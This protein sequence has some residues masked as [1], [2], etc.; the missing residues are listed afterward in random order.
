MKINNIHPDMMGVCINLVVF[1]WVNSAA[2]LYMTGNMVPKSVY[3]SG[4]TPRRLVTGFEKQYGQ[5][6]RRIEAPA[7]MTVESVFYVKSLQGGGKATDDWNTIYVVFKN[8]EIGKYDLLELPRYNTQNSYIGFEYVYDK[9]MLRR[10]EEKDATFRKGEVFA[11]SPRISESGDW[12][13]GMEVK[14]AAM[15]HFSTEE[16]GIC[17]TDEFAHKRLRCMFKHEREF[18]YNEDEFVP[19]F[20]YGDDDNPRPFPEEGEGLRQDRIVMGFRRRIPEM[21]LT[22]LT[23]KALRTPDRLY[24]ILFRAPKNCKVM[25]IQVL[26]ERM[27]NRS[28]NRNNQTFVDQEHN[29]TLIA[30][31]KEDNKFRNDIL[32]WYHRKLYANGNQD[33]DITVELG[34][35]ITQAYSNQTVNIYGNTERDIITKPRNFKRAALKD[36]NIKIVLKEEVVGKQKY[37]MS[38]MNGDKGVIV[39]IIKAADAPTYPDGTRAEVIVNNTPAFRRQIYAMLMEL[40]INFISDKIHKEVVMLRNS[41]NYKAAY[42]RLYLFYRTGFPDFADIVDRA[43]PDDEAKAEHVDYVAKHFI[44]V[45]VRSDASLYGVQIIRELSKV[46]KYKP[47][48]V[49]FTDV[50]GMQVESINPVLISNLYYMLLD[51]F[52]TDMSSQ[53]LPKAN[54]FGFPAKLNDKD[55]YAGWHKDQ[56]NKN[57]G[58]TEGRV[59]KNQKGADETLKRFTMAYSPEA[60]V[61][62][63]K[64]YIRAEDPFEVDIIVKPEEY[65]TNRA[66]QMGASMLSDS[67][68]AIRHELPSDKEGQI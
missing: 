22:M 11:L 30:Y 18:A 59:E 34:T 47:E 40:S 19:L 61:N 4:R 27:K 44:S 57:K 36:W 23:K 32:H 9:E 65:V 20:L 38:G 15:S 51:K 43:F 60:R 66:V 58:E 21:A 31:E 68:Y 14:V 12:M 1:P 56:W 45:Q 50:L 29:R 2:R 46:F 41:G 62:M 8:D 13:F 67:G 39:K 25:S 54:V 6:A 35:F 26:S 52:G 55:R 63:V 28:N 24:D 48:K 3:T 33:I 49:K 10:L 64:R 16:D 7:N 53:S 37:K 17:I 5:T 42:D